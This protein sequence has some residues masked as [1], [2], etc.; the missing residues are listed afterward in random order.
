M[1][2]LPE[3]EAAV[4]ALRAAVVGRT[5]RDAHTRHAAAR[6]A[7]PDDVAAALTG[8]RIVGVTRMGKHQALA[9]DDGSTLHAH[10]RMT[11][12]WDVGRAD[13]PLPP[14]ARVVLTFDDG[15]RVA[16]VDPRALGGITWHAPGQAPAPA[17]GP[18]ALDDAFDAAALRAALRTRR[19]AIKPALLD[20]RV[21]AGVGNIY[22]AEALWVARID[23][24]VAAASLGPARAERL[25]AAIRSVM[26]D[27]L[28]TPG[29]Y[30][31]GEA[32]ERMHVYGREGEP[33]TRCGA[34]IRRI[35]QAGRSTYFCGGCQRR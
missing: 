35:V 8:R 27:A 24:R 23:P 16:L 3:V 15:V 4:R 20:Q 9:L 29:R 18:D 32:L 26:R 12:D 11:G 2:E 17:L 28:E 21:V 5:I 25:V 6:R 33:C 19:T 10:F 13:A 34:T 1:P 14:H 30:Q 31:D 7:L 22:A